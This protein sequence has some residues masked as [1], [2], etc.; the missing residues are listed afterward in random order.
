MVDSQAVQNNV[1]VPAAKDMQLWD[2][3]VSGG[4]LMIPLGILLVAAIFFFFER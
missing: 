4:P 3:L 2:I 1:A